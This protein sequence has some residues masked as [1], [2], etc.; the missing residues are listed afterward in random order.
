MW[1]FGT[2]HVN[3]DKTCYHQE[4]HKDQI[5]LFVVNLERM[6]KKIDIIAEDSTM[7]QALKQH[8]DDQCY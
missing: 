7:Q 4:V 6:W 8:I 5:C 1:V 2:N 3:L